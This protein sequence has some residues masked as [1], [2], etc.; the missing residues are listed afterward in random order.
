MELVGPADA[1]RGESARLGA[2]LLLGLALGHRP[3]LAAATGSTTF[4]AGLGYFVVIVL[5]CVGGILFLGAL[6][7]RF[8]ATADRTEAADAANV[9]PEDGGDAAATPAEDPTDSHQER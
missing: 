2:G 5:A 1:G 3:L 9:D 8:A 4:E 7:Q 6:Y